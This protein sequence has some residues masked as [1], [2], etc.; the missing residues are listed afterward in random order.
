MD[1]GT[2]LIG[3]LFLLFCFIIFVILSR[4]NR[5]REKQLLQQLISLA[6][7]NNSTISQHDI[8]KSSA[9]GIDKTANI[10]FV[11]CDINNQSNAHTINLSEVQRCRVIN[12]NKTIN[13]NEDSYTVIGK[14]ELAF[15]NRDKNKPEAIVEFYNIDNDNATLSG[16]LQLSEKWCKITNDNC[17]DF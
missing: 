15:S 13:N 9:I 6:K 10:L 7:H 8:W 16:E 11:I 14:V 17:K 5:K 12:T 4:S 1:F 2:S 3:I